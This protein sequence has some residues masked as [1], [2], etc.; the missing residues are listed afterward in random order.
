MDTR[1][2]L[3]ADD[4]DPIAAK[5]VFD[6]QPFLARENMDGSFSLFME[7]PHAILVEVVAPKLT[8]L[9]PQSWSRCDGPLPPSKVHCALVAAHRDSLVQDVRPRGFVYA[10]T[11]PQ[12]AANLH[13]SYFLGQH[14]ENSSLLLERGNGTCFEARAVQWA[15]PE[16]INKFEFQWIHWPQMTQPGTLML[17]DIERYQLQLRSNFS[18]SHANKWDHYMDYHAGLFIDDCDSVIERLRADRVPHF[19]TPHFMKFLAVFIQDAGGLVYEVVCHKFSIVK[20]RDLPQWDFC[21]RLPPLAIDWS[22][23][24]NTTS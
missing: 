11:K 23:L 4:L 6:K 1:V 24:S 7:V 15:Q 8:V 22:P 17:Q 9:K 16:G 18:M 3:E 21:K 10:S 2:T 20:L 14:S 5:L 19:L 12:A 13:A